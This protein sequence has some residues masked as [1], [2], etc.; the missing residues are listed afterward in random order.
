M[1]LLAYLVP[2]SGVVLYEFVMSLMSLLVTPRPLS[3]LLSLIPVCD[4]LVSR[5]V[6]NQVD[7]LVGCT[8]LFES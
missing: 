8:D 5:S 3:H 4:C 6:V 1:D 2:F 7:L